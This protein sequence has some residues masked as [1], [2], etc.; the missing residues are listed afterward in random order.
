MAFDT[1]LKIDGVKGEAKTEGHA[2][3]IEVMS[4]SWGVSNASSGGSYGGGLAS[5][6]PSFTDINIAKRVDKASAVLMKMCG[7]GDP[8]KTA[9]LS[10]CK[11]TGKKTEPYLVITLTNVYVTS[12]Q[13][14]GS[15]HGEDY[16]HESLGLAYEEV[17]FEYSEQNATG[18]L[19][20][21]ATFDY[22]LKTQVLK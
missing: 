10:V 13:L 19:T 1:Y 6:K 17:K 14:S 16:P 7:G 3:E 4:F 22:N 9:T 5:G 8:K 21:G 2:D 15:A 18:G 11:S 12:L 20:K